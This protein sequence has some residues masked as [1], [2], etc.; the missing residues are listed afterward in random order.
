MRFNAKP[1]AG[2][3]IGLRA[4]HYQYILEN[5]P[6]VAWF[7]AITENYIGNKAVPLAYL[8]AIREHYPLTLHGVSLSIGSADPLNQLYLKELK[9]L[10]EIIEPA[11][12]S[13]H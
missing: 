7:E 6:N 4:N 11:W 2:A 5:L 12:V 10:I 13:D 9:N 3:G 1:I 8:L